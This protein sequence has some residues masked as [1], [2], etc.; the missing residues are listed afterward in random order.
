MGMDG[1]RTNT[2]LLPCPGRTNQGKHSDSGYEKA[3]SLASCSAGKDNLRTETIL[4]SG[5]GSQANHV[6]NSDSGHAE[7]LYLSKSFLQ[8]DFSIYWNGVPKENCAKGNSRE[9]RKQHGPYTG[10]SSYT[11]CC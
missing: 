5:H 11:L 9:R 7:G 10:I 8:F 1:F 3:G 4:L 6:K 2:N